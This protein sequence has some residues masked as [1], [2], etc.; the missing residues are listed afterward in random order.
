MA[1]H[2]FTITIPYNFL[3]II[4]Y[5]C[6]PCILIYAR[7]CWDGIYQRLG[8]PDPRALHIH[9]IQKKKKRVDFAIRDHREITAEKTGM[10]GPKKKPR[11][12][13]SNIK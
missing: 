7:V 2:V 9:K 4:C 12:I 6:S 5:T 3:N 11:D 8:A 13:L 10:K 1:A